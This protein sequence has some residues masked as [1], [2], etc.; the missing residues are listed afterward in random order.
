[1]TATPHILLVDDDPQIL[2][3]AKDILEDAGYDVE[4]AGSVAAARECLRA[5]HYSLMIVDFNLPDGTGLDLAPE[6]K[7]A[8]PKTRV[9]LMSGEASIDLGAAAPAIHSILTKPV[10]PQQLLAL[11]KKALNQ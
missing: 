6:A 11:I 5:G 10:N 1:M 8:D 9:I 4:S 2:D 3:T 7:L